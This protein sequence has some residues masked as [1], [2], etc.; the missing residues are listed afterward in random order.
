VRFDFGPRASCHPTGAS[1]KEGERYILDLQ[2]VERWK[3][4][5][6]ETAP[7][8]IRAGEMGFA[9]YAGVPLRRI[10]HARYLQPAYLITSRR[11]WWQLAS[12]VYIQP[13]ELVQVGEEATAWRAEFTAQRSGEMSLFANDS[14]LPAWLGLDP[15]FF[16][17]RTGG[18][19]S[20][21]ACVT[22]YRAARMDAS[23][24]PAPP[25]GSACGQASER[26]AAA[27]AEAAREDEVRQRGTSEGL[28]LLAEK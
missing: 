14:M 6:I 22:L 21:E 11:Q 12:P 5:S 23:G 18:G 4:G 17:E 7:T 10:V 1:V 19:N 3:D 8:G 20:G 28:T 25:E 15:R 24:L 13:L 27:R 16:Y 2:V 9:G 26:A